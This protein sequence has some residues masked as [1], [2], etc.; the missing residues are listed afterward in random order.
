MYRR[1]KRK[2]LITPLP[3]SVVVLLPILVS[4]SGYS[5]AQ[6]G[7]QP[8]TS[9]ASVLPTLNPVVISGTRIEQSSFS[10]PMSIDEVEALV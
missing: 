5:F 2:T 7:A 9:S 6:P 4:A 10:L 8:S 3:L 1:E